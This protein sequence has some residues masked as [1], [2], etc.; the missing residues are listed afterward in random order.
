MTYTRSQNHTN[1]VADENGIQTFEVVVVVLLFLLLFDVLVPT[2]THLFIFLDKWF[3]QI[4]FNANLHNINFFK[5]LNA[6]IIHCRAEGRQY[7]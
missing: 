1:M 5:V 3:V 4:Y 7:V 6:E 2:T